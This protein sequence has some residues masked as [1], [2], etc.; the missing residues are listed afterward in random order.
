[1]IRYL[2]IQTRNKHMSHTSRTG[3]S[4][5]LVTLCVAMTLAALAILPAHALDY[6][7]E[8][9][10]VDPNAPVDVCPNIGGLQVSIPTGME[11]D[12]NGNCYTPTPVTP[13]TPPVT[14]DLCSN[15]DGKQLSL[16]SGYYRTSDGRCFLQPTRPAEP[17]DVCPN[18]EDVQIAIPEGYYL[19]TDNTC[20]ELPQPT[21]A[22]PNI[23]GPQET[24]PEGMVLENER[25]FTPATPISPSLTDTGGIAN[26]PSS[27]VPLVQPIVNAV[28]EAL[29][30]WLRSLPPVVAQTA[31]YYIF[32]IVGLLAVGILLQSLREA[33]FIRQ[34][35]ILLKKERVIAEQKDMFVALAS[36]YLRTPL[37]VMESGLDTIVAG[38]ELTADAVVPLQQPIEHLREKVAVIL[39]DIQNNTALG[40]IVAP[41][42]SNDRTPSVWRS[43]FFLGALVASAALTGLA[44]F[45]FGIVGNQAIGTTNALVQMIF[46]V[47]VMVVLYM[48][49]RNLYVKRKLHAE[50][51]QLIEHEKTIDEARN[52]FI[53]ATTI[54]LR[55]SLAEI[56]AAKH[57]IETTPSANYF[58]NGY[59]R[60]QAILAKFTLLG[61]IQTGGERHLELVDV[62]QTINA[63][64]SRYQPAIT[65][66]QLTVTNAVGPLVVQQNPLLFTF[67]IESLIDNAIKFNELGGSITITANP[68]AAAL[69]LEVTDNGIGIE[70]TKLDQL[71][72]PFS[73]AT[74]AM[75][76]NYEGLGFSLFLDKIIMDYTGGTIAATSELKRGT[77]LAIASPIA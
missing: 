14:T 35:L 44:N 26:V 50:Q 54:A 45:F 5:H 76:F 31:P 41:D 33:E 16:P 30:S 18:L 53:V 51:Q 64:L 4:L 73:R 46:A 11:L 2:C 38:Q 75:E 56:D 47:A 32:G 77:T 52:A 72:Q 25:C 71:F 27:L 7:L 40:T 65:A 61:Q 29:R 28:P 67:V 58:M 13:P 6:E 62:Q 34:L 17:V 74:S 48:T 42:F 23:D 57:V 20:V 36:H 66:K 55:D 15:I 3:I 49:V 24:I 1:M 69:R 12:G 68:D 43:P 21:D 70:E 59:E 9:T 19:E 63:T 8:Q 10:I 60:L 39:N 37:T 22:C